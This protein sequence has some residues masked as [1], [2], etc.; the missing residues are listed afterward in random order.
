LQ[1]VLKEFHYKQ[2]IASLKRRLQHP[3]PGEG[4][5]ERMMARV[6][7]MPFEI[8]ANARPSA[9]L[10]LLFPKENELH[11]LLI[12]RTEDGHAHSG[13]IS[14][15]GGRQEPTDAD[16]RATAL[17]EAQ[18][19]VGIM[20]SDVTVLA[21]LTHLYIPISN[22]LVYPFIAYAE[23]EP[24]YNLSHD[25]VARVIEVPVKDIL[26]TERKTIATVTSPAD[27]SFVR[28]VN[29]YQLI[30]G[31]VIWGATAMILSEI[32]VILSEL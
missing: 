13:Q 21:P 26:S 8:P 14:F 25:E 29:A 1:I 30:D 28:K 24:A 3:L 7:A 19:E 17:R 11:L 12:K 31:S 4:A 23:K 32:E 18:E 6:K 22:F 9:V 10:S 15:P 20:S 16:L 5:H 2:A 27:K